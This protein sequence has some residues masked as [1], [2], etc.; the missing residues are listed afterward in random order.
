MS[1]CQHITFRHILGSAGRRSKGVVSLTVAVLILWTSLN[2]SWDVLLGRVNLHLTSPE[3][4][5]SGPGMYT[6]QSM[7]IDSPPSMILPSRP[8]NTLHSPLYP[9]L[10]QRWKLRSRLICASHAKLT[11]LLFPTEVEE[12]EA[13]PRHLCFTARYRLTCSRQTVEASRFTHLLSQDWTQEMTLDVCV[14]AGTLLWKII[15]GSHFKCVTPDVRW[16]LTTAKSTILGPKQ[17]A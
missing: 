11:R 1:L 15:S 12:L 4:P 17:H 14:F 5:Q 3:K 6:T 7:T 16:N 2:L 8:S 9:C 13:A 10:P